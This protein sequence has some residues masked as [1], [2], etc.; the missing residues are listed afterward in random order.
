MQGAYDVVVVGGGH[1]GL[2]AATYLARGGRRVAVLEA[3][4]TLGGPAT[5]EEVRPGF[6]APIASLV[7]LMRPEIIRELNLA[8]HGLQFVPFEPA[9]TS[10]GEDGRVLR[11]YNDPA[12]SA[13]EIAKFSAK[14]AE[15]YVKFHDFLVRVAQ[16]LDPLLLRTPPDGL[17]MSR[18][19]LVYFG[20]LA[21][22]A[23]KLGKWTMG[24]ALRFPQMALRL[25]LAEWFETELL[26][27]TLAVDALIGRWAGPWSPGTS[28]GL[29]QRFWP[30]VHGGVWAFV[31]GGTSALVDGLAAAARAAGVTIRTDAPVARILTQDGRTTG[32][33]LVSGETVN[34][35]VVASSA[36]AKR[37]LLKLID[38]SELELDVQRKI[39]HMRSTGGL[40]KIN[41]ALSSLPALKGGDGTPAPRIR[42]GPT[43]EYLERA[44]DDAKYGRVSA[45]PYVD[46]VV[47]TVV[48]PSL[49]P[50]GQHVMSIVAQF[51]PYAL[52]RG[53]WKDEKDKFAD[54]V[55]DRL[56][57]LMPGLRRA[58]LARQV[59]TP[60]DLEEKYGLSGGHIYHGEMGTDQQMFMRPIP[61]MGRYRTPIAGLYLCGSAAHPGG[62]I[63]GAPG[64]NAAREILK[65][66]G[67]RAPR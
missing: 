2:V 10:V 55:V 21:L 33:Q 65:D 51:A 57:A 63:T 17:N 40:A 8:R 38:P 62:G 9:V 44:Y 49:A 6:R 12:Q 43:L 53:T 25:S 13:Q 34:A 23:R 47:P 32:V 54:K 3:R 37:T 66:W 26:K 41:L 42:F 36:D 56:D 16:T 11:L 64:Y 61:G 18:G 7:G 67:R 30:A 14:D 27:A 22:R 4:S 19:E 39:R 35:A 50:P 59:Y 1:N 31:R 58:V 20:R 15:S 5:T 48:D 29:L 52:K 45:E 24:Q 28:F 60:V 46:A